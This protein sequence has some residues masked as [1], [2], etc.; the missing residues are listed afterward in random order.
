MIANSQLIPMV[1]YR[2]KRVILAHWK[3][4]FKRGWAYWHT[5]IEA[6]VYDEIRTWPHKGAATY[7]YPMT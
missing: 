1:I 6:T 2:L 7:H 4:A 3:C 5:R